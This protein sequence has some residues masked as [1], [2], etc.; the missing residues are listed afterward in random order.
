MNKL[1]RSLMHSS[2]STAPTTHA[3][4]DI[5]TPLLSSVHSSYS[6]NS[7]TAASSTDLTILTNSTTSTNSTNLNDNPGSNIVISRT[8]PLHMPSMLSNT[9]ST[10]TNAQFYLRKQSSDYIYIS[11]KHDHIIKRILN[12]VSDS[13]L[14]YMFDQMTHQHVLLVSLQIYEQYLEYFTEDPIETYDISAEYV[15][16]LLMPEL[17][18]TNAPIHILLA[19]FAEYSIDVKLIDIGAQRYIAFMRSQYKSF[20]KMLKQ[21][22]STL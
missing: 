4:N 3:N 14:A 7:T 2:S 17:S 20:R 10:N 22:R 9:N 15:M 5:S 21:H 19:A 16:L 1:L 11:C 12:D 18:S 13:T 8:L 6:V